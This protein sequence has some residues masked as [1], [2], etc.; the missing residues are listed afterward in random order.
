MAVPQTQWL[1]TAKRYRFRPEALSPDVGRLCSLEAPEEN[2]SLLLAQADG[3][4]PV[5]GRGKRGRGH[6][7]ILG[8]PRMACSN[9][10]LR[11]LLSVGVF[12]SKFPHFIRTPVTRQGTTPMT[13][14]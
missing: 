14:F 9:L 11:H 6:S 7:E 13:S 3:G 5:G 1:H 10:S 12:V 4:G 8:V 2:G